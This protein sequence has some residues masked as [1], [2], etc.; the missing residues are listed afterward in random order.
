MR[1]VVFLLALCTANPSHAET[2][3]RDFCL[4]HNKATE[5]GKDCWTVFSMAGGGL[6]MVRDLEI[7]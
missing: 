6:W 1:I 4:E 5:D 2:D 3:V 7:G